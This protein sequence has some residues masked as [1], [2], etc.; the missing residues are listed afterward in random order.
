MKISLMMGITDEEYV[1]H[2]SRV[3]MDCFAD[4]FDIHLCRTPE[5]L[6]KASQQVYDVALLSP[7]MM[8][9]WATQYSKL[10]IVLCD[11]GEAG[12]TCPVISKYQRI[13]KIVSKILELYAEVCE[14]GMSFSANHARITVVWSPVGGC[15]KTTV[16]LA[17]AAQKA[18]SGQETV[19]VDLENFSSVP[20]YFRADGKGISTAFEKMDT[21][22]ELL[23]KSIRQ[24]DAETGIYYFLPP[25]NYDDI[26]I[27]TV[28]D[29]ERLV[30]GCA[31]GM[32]EVILDLSSSCGDKV[33]HL[34]QIAD[35]IFLVEGQSAA[36]RTKLSQFQQQNNVYT[37]IESKLVRVYNCGAVPK[38]QTTGRMIRLPQI[39]SHDPITVYR[40]LAASPM[41]Q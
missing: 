30:T 41:E 7:D 22:L 19:Y 18:L 28:S 5:Q 34:L 40:S 20:I 27:L 32:D 39:N 14:N 26:D 36:S 25:D 29:L 12:M 23:L 1:E 31:A 2:L 38:E 24:R 16:A 15:G 10:S 35:Q 11:A 13:S 17:Y 8:Q 6:Q 21:N 37:S 9:N 33:K 4:V 3:L